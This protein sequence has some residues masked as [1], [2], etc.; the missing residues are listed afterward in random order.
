MYAQSVNM[1]GHKSLPYVSQAASGASVKYKI[2]ND[3]SLL[4]NSRYWR[5]E[6]APK[7]G[8]HQ[9]GAARGGQRSR[10]GL[11]LRKGITH[12]CKLKYYHTI[13]FVQR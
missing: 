6:Y 4:L 5:N 8:K 2:L 1:E 3:R 10:Q 13:N 12:A 11:Q 7:S 9:R